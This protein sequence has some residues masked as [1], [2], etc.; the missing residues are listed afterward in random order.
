MYSSPCLA[1]DV[2]PCWKALG[3]EDEYLEDAAGMVR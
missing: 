3:S 2:V 1:H